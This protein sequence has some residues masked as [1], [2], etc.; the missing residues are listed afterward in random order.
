MAKGH[1][2]LGYPKPDKAYIDRVRYDN[3]P[4]Q[5]MHFEAVMIDNLVQFRPVQLG[6][7]E[8]SDDRAKQGGA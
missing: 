5:G 2:F 7:K 1:V 3:L 8:G 4:V 6:R